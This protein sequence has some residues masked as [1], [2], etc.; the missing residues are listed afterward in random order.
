LA[1][2]AHKEIEEGI[3]LWSHYKM[4][5]RDRWTQTANLVF[6]PTA[7]VAFAGLST[8]N[9]ELIERGFRRTKPWGA[10]LGGYDVVLNTML[11]DGGLWHEAP[12]YPIS[13]DVLRL[14]AQVSRWRGL[15]D[16]KDW[17]SDTDSSAF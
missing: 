9:K 6:K 17:F 7:T 2:S 13:H 3:V 16:Q 10:W 8:G 5:A 12:G 15:F 4:R 14:V 1:P 11:I